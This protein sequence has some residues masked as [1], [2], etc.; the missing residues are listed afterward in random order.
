MFDNLEHFVPYGGGGKNT[1]RRWTLEITDKVFIV[2]QLRG[3]RVCK[4]RCILGKVHG[5]VFFPSCKAFSYLVALFRP[6]KD[7][8]LWAPVS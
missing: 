5:D 8:C 3:R 2:R 6:W 4:H 7:S 1:G